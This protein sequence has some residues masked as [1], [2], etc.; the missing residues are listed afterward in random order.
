MQA[1]CN[2]AQAMY[3]LPTELKPIFKSFF[4]VQK[5]KVIYNVTKY[6][7]NRYANFFHG[8]IPSLMIGC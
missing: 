7:F 5:L 3:V 4:K 6:P 2:N 8:L 1:L